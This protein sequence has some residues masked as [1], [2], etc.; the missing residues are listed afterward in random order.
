MCSVALI[1]LTPSIKMK[2]RVSTLGRVLTKI[3][4]PLGQVIEHVICCQRIIGAKRALRLWK[5]LLGQLHGRGVSKEIPWEMGKILL[6]KKGRLEKKKR[7]TK[8]CTP[9]LSGISLQ[10]IP[11][12]GSGF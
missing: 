4:S 2:S 10:N 9:T 7:Q 11:G 1:L 12:T 6:M 8:G 5:K 3:K